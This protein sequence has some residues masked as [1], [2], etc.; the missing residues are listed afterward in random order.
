[1]SIDIGLPDNSTQN[2]VIDP[3]LT[4]DE[5]IVKLVRKIGLRNDAGYGLFEV[6]AQ[7]YGN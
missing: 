3:S 4:V 1:L 7:G 6:F 5:V 2:I